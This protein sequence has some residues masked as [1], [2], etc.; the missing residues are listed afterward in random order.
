MVGLA[1]V[2]T[3]AVLLYGRLT[4]VPAVGPPVSVVSPTP[5]PTVPGEVALPGEA[6]PTRSLA[7]THSVT[8]TPTLTPA[9]TPTPTPA[10]TPT[11]TPASTPTASPVPVTEAEAKSVVGDF[12]TALDQ[13]DYEKAVSMG[14]GQGEEQIRAMVAAIEGSARERGVQ[15]DIAISNLTMDATTESGAGRLVKASFNAVAYARLGSFRLPIT[16]ANGS[17]IFLVERIDGE[18]MITNI[19]S[20]DGLPG[21]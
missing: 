15:P 9:S 5:S 11:S 2:I 7:A 6:S 17:A 16:S 18:P 12:F 8:R 14:H 1:A 20:V 13:D 3:L 21:I 10:S 4:S 19:S